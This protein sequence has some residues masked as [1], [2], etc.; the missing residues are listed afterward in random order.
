MWLIVIMSFFKRWEIIGRSW[1]S[2]IGGKN[3]QMHKGNIDR[4]TDIEAEK[5]DT[6]NSEIYH[7]LNR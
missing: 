5:L 3:L 7:L 4:A 6:L 1:H 2:N